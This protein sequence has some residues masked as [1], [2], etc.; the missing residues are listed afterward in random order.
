[1]KPVEQFKP[2]T[3]DADDTFKV[4]PFTPAGPPLP[5]GVKTVQLDGDMKPEAAPKVLLVPV[6]ETYLA[7]VTLL[8]GALDDAGSEVWLRHPEGP[9]AYRVELRDEA[10]WQ[11]WLDDPVP[12]KLRVIHR[13]DGFEL[14]TNMGKL[15][16]V[17]PNGPSVPVRG[18]RMDLPTLRKGFERVKQR[19]QEAPDVCFV[20]SMGLSLADIAAALA[21][22]YPTA[23]APIF[24]ELCLVYPRPRVKDA[25]R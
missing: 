22:N 2:L 20:P 12:G 3:N 24:S 11:E 15:P 6:G 4:A 18:G 1:M 16:G 21:T 10:A 5:E 17:D 9:L 23:D 19:F 25:G 14:Q 7:Q 13:A 8:L